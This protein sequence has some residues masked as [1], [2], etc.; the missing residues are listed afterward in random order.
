MAD[1]LGLGTCKYWGV[2]WGVIRAITAKRGSNVSL[3][4]K[5]YF[6]RSGYLL[7]KMNTIGVMKY[8]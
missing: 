7:E 4:R 6:T 1:T 8:D 5:G 3:D 2:S